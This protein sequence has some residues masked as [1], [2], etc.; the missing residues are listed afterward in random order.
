MI[1]SVGGG[2]H[3]HGGSTTKVVPY[4]RAVLTPRQVE[5]LRWIADGCPDGVW[6][7]D[8]HK[9]S[10]RALEVRNVVTVSRRGGRWHAEIKADGRYYLEHGRYPELAREP[11]PHPVPPVQTPPEPVRPTVASVAGAPAII[12]MRSEPLRLDVSAETRPRA[13][14]IL[15]SLADEAVKRGYT[16]R[17]TESEQATFQIEIGED[18]FVFILGE[19]RDKVE[20]VDESEVTAAKY[21]WQRI[22]P[23]PVTVPSGRLYLELVRGWRNPK[24]ADRRRWSLEDKLPA[25][26]STIEEDSRQ[27]QEKRRRAAARRQQR[28]DTWREAVPRAHALLTE[29]V[30]RSRLDVQLTARQRAEQIRRYCQ[31]IDARHAD[32][33]DPQVAEQIRRWVNWARHQA[34]DLDPLS[35]PAELGLVEVV[36][37]RPEDLDRHMPHGMTVRHPP[38]PSP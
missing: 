6:P 29:E 14:L 5:V 8:S 3:T 4:Q 2:R 9:I 26:L 23:K 15:R 11:V 7:N 17:A 22:Q 21:S 38:E 18:V 35:H 25:I 16:L 28:L 10:A 30:N 1:A 20:R 33:P 27:A 13:L 36:D 32:E 34:D 19:E 12:E 24:W 37:P 31:D